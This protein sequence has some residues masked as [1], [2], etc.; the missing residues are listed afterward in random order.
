[1]D[2]SIF[3]DKRSHLVNKLRTKGIVDENVLNAINTV[4]RHLFFNKSFV[5]Y[6][7]EDNAY[8]ISKGQTIS[9]PYTVAMQSELLKVE[10][11]HKILEIGTGSGYQASVLAQMGAEVYSIERQK[12]L[13]LM[14]LQRFKELNINVKNFWGDGYKGLPKF[15]PFDRIIITAAAHR[16]PEKLLLQLKYGGIMVVP[17]GVKTQIMMRVTRISETNFNYE[18]FDYFR[19]V[20]MLAGIE[21]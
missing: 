1:M 5:Q 10:K 14:C 19:F 17:V 15:A 13:Y 20:P 11:K 18:E 12:Q 2:S 6:A 8:P 21:H 16:V 3:K 4:P 7:Y 9:Q